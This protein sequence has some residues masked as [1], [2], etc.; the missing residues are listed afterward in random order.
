[1]ST[2]VYNWYQSTIKTIIR[3]ISNITTLVFSFHDLHYPI[4]IISHI[5]VVCA[6]SRS[7]RTFS[8]FW[9]FSIHPHA[10]DH[11]MFYNIESHA[12]SDPPHIHFL[13]DVQ[14]KRI[15]WISRGFHFTRDKDLN[16]NFQF[17]TQHLTMI[18]TVF[19]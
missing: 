14:L 10:L 17:K 2:F 12:L 9:S 18:E 15:G 16:S 8:H 13:E 5:I 3:F 4:V 6:R 11:H 1:M 7:Q 19:S